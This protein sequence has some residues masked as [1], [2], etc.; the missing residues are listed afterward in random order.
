MSDFDN[1]A[2]A[3]A[4][5]HPCDERSC[6]IATAL[7]AGYPDVAACL[8]ESATTEHAALS[9]WLAGGG[10]L[11][12]DLYQCENWPAWLAYHR[13]YGRKCTECEAYNYASEDREPASCGNCGATL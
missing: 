3:V 4:E 13:K 1:L 8:L 6:D 9:A 12:A 5:D 10:T 7:D 11:P 2:A